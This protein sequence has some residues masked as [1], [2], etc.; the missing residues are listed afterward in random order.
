MNYTR[1]F[2]LFGLVLVLFAVVAAMLGQLILSI[3]MLATV[4]VLGLVVVIW[5]VFR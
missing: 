3:S 4:V 2:T 5:N 1:I